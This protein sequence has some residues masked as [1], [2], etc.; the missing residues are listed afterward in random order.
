[1]AKSARQALPGTTTRALVTLSNKRFENSAFQP[2]P[3]FI[4]AD[5]SLVFNGS[6]TGTLGQTITYDVALTKSQVQTAVR[7]L[8]NDL[9]DQFE[10]GNT[11]NNSRII[12]DGLS[13]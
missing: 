7:T 3:N 2:D 8:V 4:T 11:L 9:L 6:N 10:P 12:L 1:M 13:D 5:V